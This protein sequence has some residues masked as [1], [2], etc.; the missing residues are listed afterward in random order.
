MK[1][2][3]AHKAGLRQNVGVS[4]LKV[5]KGGHWCVIQ[6]TVQGRSVNRF[7]R[8]VRNACRRVTVL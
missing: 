3:L 1:L 7:K 6:G 4:Y 5:L 8:G 2:D